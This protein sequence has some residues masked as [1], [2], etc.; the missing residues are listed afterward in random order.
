MPKSLVRRV[1]D[2][3]PVSYTGRNRVSLPFIRHNDLEGQMKAM[4]A[5]GVLFAIVDRC[6]TATSQANWKL[7]R[8]AKSGKLEDRVEVTSHPALFVLNKPNQFTTRQEM[9]EAGQQHHDL[10]GETWL[11]IGRNPKSTLPLELWNVRPDRM[12]PVPDKDNF[13]IGYIYTGAE[14][15]EVPLEIDQVI[16]IRRPNPLDPFRGFGPV[17]AVMNH[18]DGER[19]SAEWNRN[20]FI[21]GATPGAIIEVEKRLSDPEFD[22][23]VERWREQH[24]GVANAHRVAV[25]EN[26][27]KYV[28]SKLTQRDM[29][30]VGLSTLSGEKIR[31]AF[32]FPKPMLG[33]VDDVNRANAEAGE[34]VFA[35]WLVTPRLERW[36]QALNNDFLPLFGSVGEGLEFDYETPVPADREADNFERDSKVAAAVA[37]I[38]LGFDPEEVME[39]LDFPAMSYTKPKP[40][41]PPSPPPGSGDGSNDPGTEDPPEPD[42]K[43]NPDAKAAF[44]LGMF[45]I[46][47]GEHA[48]ALLVSMTRGRE[49]RD[50]HGGHR[51]TEGDPD[52]GEPWRVRAEATTPEPPEGVRPE[53][54]E[55]AGPNIQP[56]QDQWRQALDELL[57]RWAYLS[58]KQKEALLD[59]IDGRVASGDLL[60]LTTI[61]T[62]AVAEA[63][64]ALEEA[65]MSLGGKAGERIVAEALAQGVYDIHSM[66]PDRNRT[67]A[68]AQTYATILA[69]YTLT[70]AISEA[71]RVWR[72]GAHPQDIREKVKT[73]LDGLTDAYPRMILGGALT[74]AQHDG[75]CRTIAGGPEAALYADEVLDEN[76]CTPC[77]QINRKWLGNAGD[78]MVLDTYPVQGYVGCLGR[79]RCRGQVVAVWRGG[80]DWTKWVELPE[81]RT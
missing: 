10:T 76:T 24:Q 52:D 81:Q 77:N 15:E 41:S 48:T 13:I 56:L 27:A 54:P 29:E 1:T 33:S 65:M 51:R 21:N 61:Q 2:R 19:Y 71:A 30:F 70:S 36:K 25:L 62:P 59:A 18:L 23:M 8:K 43:D 66:T 49:R 72:Q 80:D 78:A 64:A 5:V 34:Y 4:G 20:F 73:H 69:R 6:A 32:A 44:H 16:F 45:M 55:G 9:V 26:G 58:D 60:G 37:M 3:T 14:G 12:R 7:Y 74:Q 46:H 28:D 35:R 67:A 63:A 57:A 50:G 17:Q 68:S 38:N 40:P 11:V 42:E 53:L 47:G 79:Q 75:R 22:E 31:E 39:W